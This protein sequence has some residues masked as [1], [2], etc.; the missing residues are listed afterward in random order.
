MNYLKFIHTDLIF[1]CLFAFN[2]E[3]GSLAMGKDLKILINT[4][5]IK[6]KN[7][8]NVKDV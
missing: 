5:F 4:F 1:C 8:K 7:V 2:G 6:E 3:R